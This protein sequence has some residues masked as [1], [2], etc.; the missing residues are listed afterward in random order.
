MIISMSN[1]FGNVIVITNRKLVRGDFLQ[2]LHKVASQKPY[3][4]LL[5]EKDLSKES[6]EALATE[7]MKICE[8]EKTLCFL[9]SDIEIARKLG[10]KNIHLSFA[11]MMQICE[12]VKDFERISIS[13]HSLCEVQRAVEKGATQIVLGTIFETACKKGVKGKGTSFVR[14]VC[15]YCIQQG[16][17]P[18]FAIGG[19]TPKNLELV[20]KAGA[21]GGCMMSYMMNGI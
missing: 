8:Q 7:V 9:H 20:M 18:V 15:E 6:Y 21:R 12:D 16:D 14:E 1:N 13:C 2:Q 17:I 10:C 3:A 5:R 19:I 11:D 4:L